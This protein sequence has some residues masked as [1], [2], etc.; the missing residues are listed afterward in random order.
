M[1]ETQEA[2]LPLQ[3]WVEEMMLIPLPATLPP[4]PTAPG[5]RHVFQPGPPECLQ[6]NKPH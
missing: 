1:R 6:K 4:A 5:G 3:G 2:K